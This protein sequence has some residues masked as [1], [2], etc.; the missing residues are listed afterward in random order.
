M[1]NLD[2][3]FAECAALTQRSHHLAGRASLVIAQAG[4]IQELLTLNQQL[5]NNVADL[6]EILT[7]ERKAKGTN[8]DGG[9]VP[10]E[11]RQAT[12]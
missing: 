7:N 3:K 8:P 11:A 9:K 4:L 2:K 5:S 12:G 6:V 1:D 10:G